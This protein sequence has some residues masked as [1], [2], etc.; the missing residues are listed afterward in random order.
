MIFF[1]FFH[2][3][4]L[5]KSKVQRI[6]DKSGA[7]ADLLDLYDQEKP[8]TI[9]VFSERWDFASHM[10]FFIPACARSA[11][12][13]SLGNTQSKTNVKA[14]ASRKSDAAEMHEIER[15]DPDPVSDSLQ[16]IYK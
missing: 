1:H 13:V 6:K 8:T 14:N 12:T 3:N 9:D 2:R 4:F 11:Y 7:P 5:D 15:I 10:D 16:F